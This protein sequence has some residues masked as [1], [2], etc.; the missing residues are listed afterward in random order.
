VP[1]GLPLLLV[2]C[3]PA[4]A[5][6]HIGP[7]FVRDFVTVDGAKI[8]YLQRTGPGPALV[9]IPGS[10]VG[11]N[12]LLPLSAA[13]DPRWNLMIVELRGHGESWPPPDNGTIESFA[14]D[15]MRAV[16]H[17]RIQQFFVGGHSIGGMIAIEIGGRHPERVKGIVSIEGWTHHSVSK[18]AFDGRNDLTLTAAKRQ[19]LTEL[20][21]PVMS[22]WTREQVQE[23]TQIWKRWNGAGILERTPLPVLEVWGDRNLPHPGRTQMQIPERPNIDIQWIAGASHYLPLER[24]DELAAAIDN[25]VRRVAQHST[26]E[27]MRGTK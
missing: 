12:D 10:L 14:A 7:G 26:T 5:Y 25:F 4:A 13:L 22:R 20:K 27:T 18:T 1:S 9:L 8:S 2:L 16:D 21:T 19:R 3:A 6:A 24:P 11:A 17:A 15:V 23:F